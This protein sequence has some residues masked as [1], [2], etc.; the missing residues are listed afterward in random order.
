MTL[1][2]TQVFML[3]EL[4]WDN[5]INIIL[6][7]ARRYGKWSSMATA[8]AVTAFSRSVEGHITVESGIKEHKTGPFNVTADVTIKFVPD[9]CE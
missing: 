7:V 5:K 8:G 3:T 2:V 1:T 6:Q 4:R 9:R